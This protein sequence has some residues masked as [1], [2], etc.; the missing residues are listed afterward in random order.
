MLGP[1][2][3]LDKDCAFSVDRGKQIDLFKSVYDNGNI[4]NPN[5]G[6][7]GILANDNI[8]K[9]CLRIGL[10]AGAQLHIPDLGADAA[11]RGINRC[12]AHGLGDFVQS[13][14][15]TAQRFFGDLNRDLF[16]AHAE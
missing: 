16:A 9:I 5:R 3:N 13:Q 11:R 7:A 2:I 15:V 14:A 1:L 6:P 8:F 10:V 12:S 4:F